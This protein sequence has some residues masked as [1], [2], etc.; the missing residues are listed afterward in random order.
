MSQKLSLELLPDAMNMS[1][2]GDKLFVDIKSAIQ[3]AVRRIMVIGVTGALIFG[4]IAYI[5]VTQ[6]PIYKASATVIVDS[7][8][9]NVIDLG[10]VISGAALNTP[11]I[12]TEVEVMGSRTLMERVA[13]KLNL[14]ENPEF[15]PRLLPKKEPGLLAS[16]IGALTGG[17]EPDKEVAAA[18]EE[19]IFDDVVTSLMRKIA[20]SRVG[21]TYLIQAVA[22][23]Q[24]P[25][26]AASLANTVAE[27]YGVEQLEAKLE[28]TERATLWLAD[29]VD[30]LQAEVTAKENRVEDYR[31]ASGLLTAQGTT[32][33]ETNIAQLQSQ[34]VQ[35]ETDLGRLS[36]RY[37]SMRRQLDSGTGIDALGEVLD[38]PVITQLKTQLAEAQRKVA[39]FESRYGPR[40]PALFAARNEVADY[41]RQIDNEIRR[42]T[43]NLRVEVEVAQEQINRLNSRIASSR[44]TLVQNNSSQVKLND[45]Q[46]D[47]E[48]SRLILEEF[49]Q[50]FKQTREQDALVQPDARVLSRA[51]VPQS[52]ASPRKVL[53]FVVGLLLGGLTGVGLALLLEMFD[54]KIGSL[55]EI[56]RKFG[57][58]GLGS[59]PFIK[60][61]RI[62]GFGSKPPGEFL[63]SNPLSAYA[64]SMR[65][66][67]ASIAIAHMEE[68]AKTVT[69]TSS[70]P[71]EGKTSLTLSLGRMSALSGDPTLI[72]DGDFRRRQL[73]TTAG[74]KPETGLVE[75]LLGECEL[76]EAIY[77]DQY[78][79]LDILAL[80]PDG[81]NMHDVFGSRGFDDLLNRL[82][83][84]YTLILIDTG[85]LLLMAEAGIIASKTDKTLMV[86]RWRHSRRPAVRRA[87]EVLRS[88]KADVMGIALNM[89]DLT[90]KRHHSEESVQSN[91]YRQYYTSEPRFNWFNFGMKK[92]QVAP[93][94]TA[95][96]TAS[97]SDD[98]AMDK[99]RALVSRDSSD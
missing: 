75:H 65:F 42:I 10:A 72:I 6:T 54:S 35:L 59:V 3:L 57:V 14:V 41:T 22:S 17:G 45:L 19:E 43:E 88:M 89:V 16:A 83:D 74:L 21:T 85:P 40:Y 44:S 8:Q 63:L 81:S 31:S 15:N 7:R 1:G 78:T 68:N 67:R 36:S 64:E 58:P 62:L 51:S 79:N 37:N 84:R 50:R 86:V 34:K 48:A 32:L 76:E 99:L 4:T 91:S 73:T 39:E 27:Q 95:Q 92:N 94:P 96:E 98:Q 11:V 28:A 33:T 2:G 82:K 5:T 53:N 30:V 25:E 69:I 93:V 12:D 24:S 52:P 13:R 9:T 46:R 71:N 49:I 80:T 66:L 29:R 20:I 26:M 60:T 38:S 70:L 47:A 97:R 55:E 23:S 18:S 61:L 56:E 87:L 90:K 77:K